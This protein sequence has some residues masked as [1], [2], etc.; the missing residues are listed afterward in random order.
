M[1]PK[2]FIQCRV[3]NMSNCLDTTENPGESTPSEMGDTGDTYSLGCPTGRKVYPFRFGIDH[4][5]HPDLKSPLLQTRN[6]SMEKSAQVEKSR[7]NQYETCVESILQLKAC[8]N[9]ACL[10]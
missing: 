4:Y 10:K 1:C 8:Y 3:E 7:H 2:E 5:Q 9:E 6:K